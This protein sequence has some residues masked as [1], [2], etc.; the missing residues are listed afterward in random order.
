VKECFLMKTLANLLVL[1]FLFSCGLSE[2]QKVKRA[3]SEANF[4]LTK[5]KCAEAK[6]ALD[7]VSYQ[8]DNPDYI[9][10][11]ASMYGCKAG[12]SELD[13]LFGGNI[14]NVDAT[15]G[16]FLSSLAGLNTSNE[17]APDST[18][19][20]NLMSGI[21]TLLSSGSSAQ[22]SA[23]NRESKFGS[24]HGTDI[25]MQAIY[26]ILIALGKWTAYYGDGSGDGTK[27]SG[28]NHNC[29][30][31]Y[32]NGKASTAVTTLGTTSVCTMNNSGSPDID[33]AGANATARTRLCNGIILYNNLLDIL[34]NITL[35]GSSELG[36]LGSVDTIM[37]QI[38]NAAEFAEGGIP[39]GSSAVSTLRTVTSQSFC[40]DSANVTDDELQIFYAI[41]META[42]Q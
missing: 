40:E 1:T 8:S 29:F 34:G 12:Y 22:P 5:R 15:A 19:F 11:Y 28:G 42:Y 27:G 38:Y 33:L 25:N 32:T 41:M 23:T 18:S 10:M 30:I 39:P 26:M 16:G 9:K 35:S 6:K 36:D 31:D 3:I 14:G 17:T 4:F 13:D 24:R 7:S 20:T 37:D 2:E 21:D